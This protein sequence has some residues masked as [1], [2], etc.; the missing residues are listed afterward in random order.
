MSIEIIEATPEE[1]LEQKNRA[2]SINFCRSVIQKALDVTMDLALT[3][4]EPSSA[5]VG[6][7]KTGLKAIEVL[8][9]CK[10]IEGVDPVK[11]RTPQVN[12][13]QNFN[14]SQIPE[15]D[16]DKAEETLLLEGDE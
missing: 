15:L 3:D 16:F 1:T 6:L 10:G 2:L 14:G 4:I 7:M 8:A 11:S 13:L 5:Q 9:R 12:V